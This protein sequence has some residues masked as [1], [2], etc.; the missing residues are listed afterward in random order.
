MNT[1]RSDTPISPILSPE[2]RIETPTL[3]TPEPT[4]CNLTTPDPTTLG[5]PN[6][7]T[8]IQISDA[9]V[10]PIS[11]EIKVETPD[12][13]TPEPTLTTPDPDTLGKPNIQISDTADTTI[14][15]IVSPEIKIE[16]TQN[17]GHTT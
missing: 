15:P 17:F 10:S 8:N 7:E 12:L 14:S 3:A 1:I 11:P 16:E 9:P 13:A 6:K 2:I 4:L 5:K